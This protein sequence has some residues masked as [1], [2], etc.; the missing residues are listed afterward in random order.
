MGSQLTIPNYFPRNGAQS[1][2][3]WHL[4]ESVFLPNA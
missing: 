2:M 4:T 1:A 3:L